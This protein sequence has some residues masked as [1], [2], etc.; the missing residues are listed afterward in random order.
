MARSYSLKMKQ[1]NF[2]L[3]A[4]LQAAIKALGYP[5]IIEDDY[6]PFAS[7]GY[8]PCTLNGED[9]GLMIRFIS[10]TDAEN[11]DATISLHWSGDER[12]KA[13]AM[14]FAI[15]LAE[16]F[17]AIVLDENNTLQPLNDLTTS[18]KKSL[19]SMDELI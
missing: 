6:V 3:R 18:I 16:S 5:L 19:A 1:E 9:A 13:T 7:S 8:L 14:I 12:E 2:P 17:E 11:Q 15:A 10:S 4:V